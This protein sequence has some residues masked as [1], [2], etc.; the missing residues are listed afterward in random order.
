MT[1]YL[2]RRTLLAIP[3][4]LALATLLFLLL[5]AAPGR[6]GELL[7]RP[8]LT[9]ELTA[10]IQANLG[11]DQPLPVRYVRWLAALAR[12]DLGYSFSFGAPVGA[13]I[14]SVLPNTLLLAGI[15][16]VLAFLG[17]IA[18]G[19]Y[20]ALRH[21]RAVDGVL[22]TVILAIYS[23]PS[24]WLG[25]LFILI[26]S[27]AAA[28][29]WELPFFFPASGAASTGAEFM[30]FGERLL[31]RLAHLVLP[32]AT[33]TL[34]MASGVARYARTATLEVLGRDYVLAARSRGLPERVVILRHVLPNALLPL[35]TVFG[36]YL[37]VLFSGAVFVEAVFAWPGM[38]LLMVD[39][40][41]ARDYPLILGGG[42]LFGLIVVMGNV[43]ADVLYALADPRVRYD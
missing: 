30:T 29:V 23:I 8:G 2:V 28:N 1:R 32:A 37:P 9:P 26:F 24:F 31:D 13:V 17:G 42:L 22:S 41:A 34:A 27:W 21:G 4:L 20:Q 35:I 15:S 14:R 18:V 12:G 11:L 7:L 10:Q 19:V 6:P 40:V 16:L 33:L 38:G 25:I 39:A 5:E 3:L 43:L 36:L